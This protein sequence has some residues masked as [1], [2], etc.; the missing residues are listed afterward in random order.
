M[1]GKK[2]IATDNSIFHE[3][4]EDNNYYVDKTAFLKPC[5]DGSIYR[6]IFT[7]P[8]RFGKS[9]TLSMIEDFFCLNYKNDPDYDERQKNLF[10]DL[11]I[12][13]DREFCEKHR[14]KYPVIRVSFQNTVRNEYEG[15]LRRLYST[16]SQLFDDFD[17]LLD[18]PALDAD[19]RKVFL[20]IKNLSESETSD[21][22][23]RWLEDCFY[24]LVRLLNKCYENPV[25][26]L[27][28]EYDTPLINARQNGFFSEIAHIIS[29][30]L[31]PFSDGT[32][33]YRLNCCIMA[34]CLDI[35]KYDELYSGLKNFITSGVLDWRYSD[36]F[37]FTDAEVDSLLSY[38]GAED[39]KALIKERYEGY[40]FGDVT[41]YCPWDVM[42]Y[43]MQC[44]DGTGSEPGDYWTDTSHNDIIDDFISSACGTMLSAL[45][46]LLRGQT[47]AF[48]LRGNFYYPQQHCSKEEKLLKILLFTGYLT[49]MGKDGSDSYLLKIPNQ[50]IRE[51]FGT[52]IGRYL[53]R[54]AD[55]VSEECKDLCEYALAGDTDVTWGCLED[56]FEKFRS[57]EDTIYEPDHC[58]FIYRQLCAVT[59]NNSSVWVSQEGSDKGFGALTLKDEEIGT[60]AVLV[61]CRSRDFSD[62][63][64]T[65]A[66]ELGLKQ[67]TEKNYAADF[68]SLKTVFCYGIGCRGKKVAVVSDKITR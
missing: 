36:L 5:I 19:D 68:K 63:S 7:R 29:H 42:N 35:I 50:E 62:K 12:G 21:L 64:L 6:T 39:K 25:I 54:C 52:M 14:G 23:D 38:Y 27:I 28:D 46:L 51:L 2:T 16:V 24:V 48:E 13:Q 45:N 9:L 66:A 34:G 43:M 31:S 44:R 58:R 3:F 8:R 4:I 56:L 1:T 37:G 18:N 32:L 53:D 57:A 30:M 33:E 22:N 65:D 26:L 20:R 41:V 47:A 15:A 60:A 59:Q 40:R 67:I 55:T 17:F 61:F 11:A 10:K 49:C